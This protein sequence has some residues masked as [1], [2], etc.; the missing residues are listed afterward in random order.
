VMHEPE[1]SDS[2]VVA[3]KPTNKAERS[4]A[5]R[6]SQGRRPRG[7]R[8]SKARAG[9]RTGQGVTGAGTR[10]ASCTAKEKGEVH[11]APAPC[12]PRHAANGVLR[13]EA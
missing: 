9:R 4:V 6:W 2:V 12:R 7:T 10:T 8:A 11:L 13:A 3:G 5:E 1:K